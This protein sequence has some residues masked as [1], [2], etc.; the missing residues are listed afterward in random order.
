MIQCWNLN[1]GLNAMNT[2][3]YVLEKRRLYY[4]KY[5]TTNRFIGSIPNILYC[6]MLYLY[7]AIYYNIYYTLYHT[8]Y[9]TIYFILY[10]IRV[11]YYT[12]IRYFINKKQL[13]I[14]L[15]C[16]YGQGL[17]GYSLIGFWSEYWKKKCS[18]NFHN[19][20]YT[21]YGV[22]DLRIKSGIIWL[23]T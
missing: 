18:N 4:E 10:H 2:I 6:Y 17:M 14:T 23:S 9:H 5:Y 11:L 15:K 3:K 8:L 12:T 22:L 20:E 7:Y 1:F 21:F 16:H 13:K 19:F